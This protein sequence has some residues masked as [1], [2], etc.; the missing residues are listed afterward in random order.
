MTA[1]GD[2][3]LAGDWLAVDAWLAAN[4]FLPVYLVIACVVIVVVVER[5]FPAPLPEAERSKKDD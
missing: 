5:F 4:K 2:A 1:I 3:L